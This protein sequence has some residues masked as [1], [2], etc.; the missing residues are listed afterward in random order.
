MRYLVQRA[1]RK[2]RSEENAVRRSRYV[3]GLPST[4]LQD[5]VLAVF[6]SSIKNSLKLLRGD[7]ANIATHCQP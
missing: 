1:A 4:T 7:T 3:I 5:R 2:V 6:E